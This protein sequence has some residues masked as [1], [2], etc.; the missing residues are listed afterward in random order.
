MN[1][2]WVD[3]EARSKRLARIDAQYAQQLAVLRGNGP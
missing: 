1:A 3:E 2:Q